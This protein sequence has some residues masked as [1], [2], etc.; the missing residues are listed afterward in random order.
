M[1]LDRS[2]GAAEAEGTA[3]FIAIAADNLSTLLAL[4]SLGESYCGDG[5]TA[6]Y[7]DEAKR[8]AR[9]RYELLF[10]RGGI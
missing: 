9:T 5:F 2:V 6:A 3:W 8:I 10:L 7:S 4:Q 1:A